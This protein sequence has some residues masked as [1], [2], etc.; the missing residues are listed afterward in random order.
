MG[1][2]ARRRIL[3]G[4]KRRHVTAGLWRHHVTAAARRRGCCTL[5]GSVQHASVVKPCVQAK[6]NVPACFVMPSICFLEGGPLVKYGPLCGLWTTQTRP[7]AYAYSHV[8]RS[9]SL[10]ADWIP[11]HAHSGCIP[12]AAEVCLVRGLCDS[13]LFTRAQY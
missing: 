6:S 2:S 12:H 9:P 8:Q 1:T 13:A 3:N 4:Q 10:S 11:G 5:L 7:A